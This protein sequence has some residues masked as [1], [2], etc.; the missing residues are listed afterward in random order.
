MIDV[1]VGV[2]SRPRGKVCFWR[3]ADLRSNL[4]VA[5]GQQQT[6]PSQHNSVVTLKRQIALLLN[7]DLA[8]PAPDGMFPTALMRGH[9]G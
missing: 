2:K 7:S 8:D 9:D 3:K 5:E 4:H 1:S 6:Y